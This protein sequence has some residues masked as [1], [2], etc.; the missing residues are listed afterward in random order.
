MPAVTLGYEVCNP[1]KAFTI[2]FDSTPR[3]NYKL[4]EILRASWTGTFDLS[5]VSSTD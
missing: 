2:N 5:N 1:S 4:L 3:R